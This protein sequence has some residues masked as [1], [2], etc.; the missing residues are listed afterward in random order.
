MSS[1]LSDDALLARF[2]QGDRMAAQVLTERLA[3]RALAVALRVLGDRAEAEDVTQE[4]MLRL[5]RFAP[6][7]QP[8]QARVSTWLYR[9]T[10]NLCLDI[11]RRHRHRDV[12]LDTAP[13]VYR[14]LA[15]GKAKP[16]EGHVIVV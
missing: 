10:M 3:P 6:Q 2:A 5:W 9:V 14:R 11:R 1:D 8:G 7:W 4:A 12:G 16:S 15:D 13:E